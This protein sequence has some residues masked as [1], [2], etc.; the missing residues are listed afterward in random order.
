MQNKNHTFHTHLGVNMTTKNILVQNIDTFETIITFETQEA[1]D[2]WMTGNAEY[3][4]VSIAPDADEEYELIVLVAPQDG[5]DFVMDMTTGEMEPVD[6]HTAEQELAAKMD[7]ML[8]IDD[9][10]DLTPVLVDGIDIAPLPTADNPIV[11]PVP[12]TPPNTKSKKAKGANM[13]TQPKKIRNWEILSAFIS[14]YPGVSRTDVF[15]DP[16]C[17]LYTSP[18]PRDRQKSRMP[19]SA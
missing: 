19:S 6:T 17:L 13:S 5:P 18:S 8:E 1:F 16:G 10:D 9:E 7:I 4:I 11:N 3:G 15:Q 12:F 14:A 2:Y